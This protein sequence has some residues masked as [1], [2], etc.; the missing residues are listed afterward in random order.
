MKIPDLLGLLRKYLILRYP[1]HPGC[2]ACAHWPTA[3][4]ERLRPLPAPGFPIDIVYT[5]VDGA[6]PVLA[7]KR[8]RYSPDKAGGEASCGLSL[9]RD[10]D[11]LR[12]ALRSLEQY[13]PWVRRVHIV[14]DGQRPAWLDLDHPKI[15]LVDHRDYIPQEYLP[16]FNSHVIEAFLHRIPDLAEHY[17]YCN[18][19]F[20]LTARADPAF[21]FTPNGLPHIFTDWRA[22]RKNGIDRQDTPFSKSYANVRSY[23][24][25]KGLRAPELITA[26]AHYPQNKSNAAA[27]FTFFEDAVR[28][29]APQRFRGNNEMAFYCHAI[30]LWAYAKG[31]AVPVDV[32]F[33]YMNTKRFDRK[34]YYSA[35]LK[36]KDSPRTPALLCLND[37]GDGAPG[38]RW[39]DDMANF[40]AAF[41]PAPSS[42]E[43]P[44]A[45]SCTLQ[46]D[47]V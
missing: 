25:S 36:E 6:D 43:R 20:F 9:Y 16:T 17:V 34:T 19:D 26:H 2:S 39:R 33:Y 35:L 11:E 4:S 5:W 29:F 1:L 28:D 45:S 37:V 7:A 23:M 8:A 30:P 27:A 46:E 14:T 10:N 32:P 22:Y 41:Y 42:F 47:A 13:A 15:H 24:A 40:L 31:R 18:D 12:Y 21:F 44:P 3:L 38:S